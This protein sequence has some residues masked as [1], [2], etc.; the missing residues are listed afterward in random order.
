[1]DDAIAAGSGQDLVFDL[2]LR[3][4][5]GPQDGQPTPLGLL[6]LRERLLANQAPVGHDANLANPELTAQ[7]IDHWD[8]YGHVGGVAGPEFAADRP[9]RVLK[10]CLTGIYQ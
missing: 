8:Q 10:G 5:A 6:Q 1:V 4:H 7:A 2:V 3:P 9:F